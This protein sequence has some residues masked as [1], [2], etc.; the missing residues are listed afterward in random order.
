MTVETTP[1]GWTLT[2]YI[3][4]NE[5]IRVA[6]QRFED[7]RDRRYTEVNI[8]KE[9]AL[10]IK[11]TA[12]LAALQLA[13]ESQAY[14]EQQ[15]DALRDKSLRDSGIYA[16]NDGVTHAINELRTS[17]TD[18]LKPLVDFVSSQGGRGG[19][20]KATWTTIYMAVGGTAIAITA[21]YQ[22]FK[23]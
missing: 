5:A 22:I 6:G 13:R 18:A 3:A 10:K 1:E 21:L 17:F 23:H 2:A 7:E 8:E 11:E 14:K 16:T 19:G 12:D 4:H 20:V 9:K 15:N